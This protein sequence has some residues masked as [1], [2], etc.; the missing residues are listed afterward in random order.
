MAVPITSIIKKELTLEEIQQ[1][2]L[3]VLQSLIV[4]QEQAL[5]KILEITGEMDDAGMLDAVQAMIKAREDIAEIAVNQASQEPVTN[6]INNLMNATSLL[7][8]ID[9][10]VTAKLAAS[11][12]DGLEEAELHRE[13]TQKVGIV[14]LMKAINDPDI[15][16]AIKFG[17]HFL[18]G[19]GK[20]LEGK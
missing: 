15:N 6:L 7:T 9:P 10:D 13:S 18:K 5:N 16:R 12:K 19:M 17:L 3:L 4:E 8:S 1:K 11:I 2:K 14:S 20:G